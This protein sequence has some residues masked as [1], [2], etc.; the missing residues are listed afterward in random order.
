MTSPTLRRTST[1]LLALT[2]LLGSLLLA[3]Q[4]SQAA[5]KVVTITAEGVDPKVLEVAPGDTVTFVNEDTSFGY[6]A[7]AT[8][9]NWDLDSGP[10]GL[11]P[12]RSYRHPDPI[13]EAGT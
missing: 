3:A 13:T 7:Q 6:R 8:S 9:E 5:D 11:L 4:A 2:A 12:R 1:L 10:V